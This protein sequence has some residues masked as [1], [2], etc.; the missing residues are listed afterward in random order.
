ML[1]GMFSLIIYPLFI[2]PQSIYSYCEAIASSLSQASPHTTVALLEQLQGLQQRIS[3]VF[4]GE[5][6]NSWIGGK[7]SKPSLDTI[8]GWLEGRFT[9]LVTGDADEP[10][11]TAENAKATGQP[12][13]GP[14]AHYSTISSTTPSARSSP[15]P[16]FTNLSSLPPQRTT[17]AM[18]TTTPYSQVQVERASSAMGYIRQKPVIQTSRDSGG[19]ISSS[20]SSPTGYALNGQGYDDPY[21]PK[22]TANPAPA[23]DGDTPIQ[24]GSSWWGANDDNGVTSTPTAATFMTVDESSMQLS[25]DGFVSLMDNHSYSVGPQHQS[26][27]SSPRVIEEEGDDDLGLGNSKPK[28][29]KE[30]TES[31]NEA[32]STPTQAATPTPAKPAGK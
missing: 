15:Q 11:P 7:L 18:A 27:S 29:K 3:G 26:G 21:T 30:E 12:F 9:K 1:T 32:Q 23:E 10:T 14:F 20:Q 22:Y 16:S 17:S 31:K 5:K 13:A 25:G 4:H 8:G 24:A 6:G 28:P 19:S 2:C